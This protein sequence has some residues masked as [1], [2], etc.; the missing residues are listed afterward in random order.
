M[1]QHREPPASTDFELDA[2]NEGVAVSR[3]ISGFEAWRRSLNL[4]GAEPQACVSAY[5]SGT[6]YVRV[7]KD[8]SVA[9]VL[10][11]PKG[12]V[13]RCIERAIARLRVAPPPG[14]ADAWVASGFTMGK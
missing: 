7:R 12:E 10:V 8:G 5:Y 3:K 4:F 1:L 13:G 9:V 2:A 14:G 11:R 6:Y